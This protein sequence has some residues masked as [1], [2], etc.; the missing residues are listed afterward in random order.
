MRLAST[1]LRIVGAVLVLVG[2]LGL[3]AAR[4]LF[5]SG[6]FGNHVAASLDDRR[7]SGYV[8]GQLTNVLLEQRPGLTPVRPILLGAVETVV[9]SQPFRVIAQRA[10]ETAHASVVNGSA[11]Q[12]VLSIPDFGAI[13]QSA[14]SASPELAERIPTRLSGTVE[15]LTSLPL[16]RGM[17]R[18]LRLARISSEV[19]AGVLLLGIALSGLGIATASNQRHA[20]LRTGEA[21]IVIAVILFAFAGLPGRILGV[22]VGGAEGAAT[23]GLWFNF[24]GG[25]RPLAWVLA[26]VGL[27]CAAA[28]SS[29]EGTLDIRAIGAGA[30]NWIAQPPGSGFLRIVRATSLLVAGMAVVLAPGFASRLLV[31]VFGALLAFLGLRE[32]F[33][34]ALPK[35]GTGERSGRS[36]GGLAG[37]AAMRVAMT[38]AV[39]VPLGAAALYFTAR[40]RERPPVPVATSACNGLEELCG[41]RLDQVVFPGTH[42]SMA[43]ASVVDWYMPN[44][45]RDIG[46]QLRDGIRALLVDVTFGTPAGD[47]VQTLL[48]DDAATRKTYEKAVGKEGVAAALRIR[49]RLVPAKDAKPDLYMCH[50]FCELGSVKFSDALEVVRDFLV[51]NPGEVVLMVVQD[52]GVTAQQVADAI[53]QSGLGP[54]VYRG[55]F[56]APWPTLGELV[57]RNQRLLVSVEHDTGHPWVPNAYEIFQETPYAFPTP[58]SMSCDPNR[59]AATNSLFLVNHFIEHV[60]PSPTAAAVV[61]A[62]DFL[63]ARAERCEKQRK[64]VP[65]ILA[66]DF[67]RTG[68]VVAVAAELNKAAPPSR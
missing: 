25:L 56:T 20:L 67:Y 16:A 6:Q 34:L 36:L 65:N 45:E 37:G 68:D 51:G 7:V 23:T 8:A 24:F 27:A 35:D 26:T 47:K 18:L 33:N 60:P 30:R 55:P 44:Q 64:R 14:V 52:E 5:N 58:E 21:W 40:A 57:A 17:S 43:A 29:L 63:L 31:A 62:R 9:R 48:G 54:M 32:I 15:Q 22:M 13:L 10:A 2:L 42:N 3:Y 66:V 38:A 46:S 19:F 41:R 53:E 28:V 39:V 59:G 1:P 49:D 61:N 12:L 11:G 50:G 4:V